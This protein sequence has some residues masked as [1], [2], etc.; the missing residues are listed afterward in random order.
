MSDEW[1]LTS[2][3]VTEREARFREDVGTTWR[4]IVRAGIRQI[5]KDTNMDADEYL[6][7]KWGE[8]G[9]FSSE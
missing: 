4:Y 6:K 5:C 7:S 9:V 1:V 3:K 2:F 8:S